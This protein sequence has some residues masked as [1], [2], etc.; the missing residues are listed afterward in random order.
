[1]K[2]RCNKYEK[3][4]KHLPN[5][6]PTS[7]TNPSKNREHQETGY[8]K[9]ENGDPKSENGYQNP[10]IGDWKPNN[11]S[12]KLEN[13]LQMPGPGNRGGPETIPGARANPLHRLARE[14][15]EG[16][17]PNISAPGL[18]APEACLALAV[19]LSL[20]HT[21]LKSPFHSPFLHSPCMLLSEFL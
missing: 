12:R 6:G 11:G 9:P 13:G 17:G 10:E 8:W 18:L 15:R 16:P 19:A 1:M 3:Y 21:S 20:T 4:M 14:A 2:K 5:M 7:M